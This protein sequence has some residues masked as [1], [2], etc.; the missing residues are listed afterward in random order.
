MQM[1]R[2]HEQIVENKDVVLDGF[3][4]SDCSFTNCNIILGNETASVTNCNFKNCKLSFKPDSAAVFALQMYEMFNPG[5]IKF[6]GK[7]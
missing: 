4:W 1:K 3:H 2:K 6:N 7:L 5:S